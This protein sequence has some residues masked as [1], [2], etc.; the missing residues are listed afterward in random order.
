MAEEKLKNKNLVVIGKRKSA[1]AKATIKQ[2]KGKIDIKINGKP[3]EFFP[4]LQQL[5]LQEPIIIAQDVFE[6]NKDKLNFEIR[7][8]VVGGGLSS[9]VAASR[10]AI[11]RAIVE[12]TKSEKLKKAYIA[13]DRH[14]IIADTRRKEACKP[15]DSKARARR[16]TSYR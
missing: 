3:I 15:G 6:S 12:F 9:R 11:A 14:L 8:N 2:G 5:E 13:Y 7:V 10:L 4:E 1:V 16:Q